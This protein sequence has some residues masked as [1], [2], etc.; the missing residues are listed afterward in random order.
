[1]LPS[2]LS[3]VCTHLENLRYFTSFL[4]KASTQPVLQ[5]HTAHLTTFNSSTE[6]ADNSF[7]LQNIGFMHALKLPIHILH[8]FPLLLQVFAYNTT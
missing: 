5:F 3:S 7:G 2:C 8:Q 4:P 6:D 1:M